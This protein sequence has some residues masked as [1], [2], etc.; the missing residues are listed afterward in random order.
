MAERGARDLGDAVSRGVQEMTE[1][2][3]P[4]KK[5][6]SADRAD[7]RTPTAGEVAEDPAAFFSAE[8]QKETEKLGHANILISGRTGAGK[9]TLVNAFFRVPLAEEGIGKP[10]TNHVQRHE[11]PGVPVTI[12]DTPGIELGHAK[13]DVIRDYKK[14]IAGRRRGPVSDAIHV[15]WYCINTGQARIQDYDIEIVRALA[16]EL[17]VILVLTQCIDDEVAQ[18]LEDVISEEELPIEGPPARV[19]ARERVVADHRLPPHGLEELAERTNNI[20]PEAVRR[21]F[22]NALGVAIRLKANRAR[23]VVAASSAT[24]AG[25]GAAPIPVPDAV[26]LMP[27]QLG[28]LASITAI[29]GVDTSND[30]MLR[31]I[32]DLVGQRGIEAVGQRIAANLLRVLPG[33]NVI[34]AAVAAAL[35]GA[36]GEAYIHLCSEMMR[37]QATGRPMPEGEMLP[38]LLDAYQKAFKKARGLTGKTAGAKSTPASATQ[39]SSPRRKP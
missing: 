37:R 35:T 23:G 22:I 27:V 39:G 21:A 15:A 29:F 11:L 18:A 10:V 36:L 17:P 9:S 33:V 24:A 13:K 32:R 19:L 38:F 25:I 34:N 3:R 31:L 30:R 8:Q 20:L 2:A 6:D 4:G 5:G 16:D 12:F 14:T 1:R 26:V 28:M 7:T